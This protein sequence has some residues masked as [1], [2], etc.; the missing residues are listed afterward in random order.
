MKNLKII[1]TNP[2]KFINY[3]FDYA[4]EYIF[5]PEFVEVLIRK[6]FTEEKYEPLL[7]EAREMAEK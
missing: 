4:A 1:Y 6:I 5:P 7:K 2:V 3:H